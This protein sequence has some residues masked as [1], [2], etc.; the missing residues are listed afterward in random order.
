MIKAKK[1]VVLFLLVLLI[2]F[3][4]PKPIE[5]KKLTFSGHGV[6]IHFTG[7]PKDI[8]LIKVADFKYVRMDLIWS[9]IE[10]RKK[11]Y[12]FQ[13]T[14]Y[15]QLTQSLTNKGITP[16]YILDYSNKLY[17]QKN[18]IVTEKGRKAYCEFVAK[19][20]N[21]YKNNGIIWEIWN[22]PNIKYWETQPN[23]DDY[24]LLVERASKIIKKNDPSGFV[25]APA[26]AG[27]NWKSIWMKEVFKRG[28]LNYIDG[29]SVHPYR[30]TIPETV[31]Q[32]Y[33]ALKKLIAE[34]TRKKIPIISGEWGYSTAKGWRGL[35][36]TDDLQAAYAVRM[37]LINQYQRVP[38]SI[39]YDWKNDGLDPND[40]EH[41]FGLR[42]HDVTEPKLGYYAVKTVNNILNGFYFYKRLKTGNDNDYLIVFKDSLDRIKVAGWTTRNIHEVILPKNIYGKI[43][44][45][46]GEKIGTINKNDT[47]VILSSKPI[48][49]LPD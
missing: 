19:A 11:V 18:S 44:T 42:G 7:N 22:E 39:W 14:G 3:L 45:M 48:Y 49:I 20:T 23:Y 34:F 28:I 9:N 21:R 13:N 24:V 43:I 4:T 37:F 33:K 17:E 35:N 6:N 32:D 2:I 5:K 16:Y 15:D 25:V 12:D 31:V 26:L 8:G 36:L 29:F 40:G 46:Y 10:R 30:E 41:N 38:I 47:R 1:I 27:V